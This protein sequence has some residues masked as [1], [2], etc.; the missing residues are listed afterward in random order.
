[1]SSLQTSSRAEELFQEH[2]TALLRQI[3]RFFAGLMLLQWLGGIALALWLSPK[4]WAGTQSS[5]HIHVY[6]A[7]VLGGLISFI[8]ISLALTRPGTVLTRHTIG[9]CQALTSALLIHLSGGR[10]ETHFHVFGSLAFLA[11][12]RDWRVLVTSSAVVA[13]DH[14]LRGAFWPAS[15]YG[16]LSAGNWR[17]LEHAGWVVFEDCFLIYSCQRS[18]REMR[19]IAERQSALETTNASIELQVVERTAELAEARDKALEAARAK[20]EFLA[21]MS[22][23]IRTPMNG[24][25]GM[26]G[27]ILETNLDAEQKDYANTVRTCSESLLSVIND[28]L[29]FS[30]IEAGKL[31]LDVS[32][33][34]LQTM[35][36]ETVDILVTRAEEKGLELIDFVH[37]D[38]PRLLRGDPGRLRQVLLNL[39]NNAV[40]FTERGEVVIRVMPES[41]RG[42]QAIL[43]FEVDDTGI[44]IPADRMDRLFQSFSQVDAS[45]TRRYGGTGLG[46]VICKRLV[47]AMGGQ[48]GVESEAGRGSKFWFTM[49]V[50]IQEESDVEERLLL[51]TQLFGQR[52]LVVDDNATN[53]QVACAHLHAWGLRCEGTGSPQRA[54]QMMHEAAKGTP[55]LVALLD[56]QMPDMDGLQLGAAIKSD[57]VL[58]STRLLLLT[59]VG[60]RGIASLA[61]EIGFAVCLTKP[62]KPGILRTALLSTLQNKDTSW[63]VPPAA[64]PA[65]ERPKKGLP[66]P[67]R[68]LLAE[69]NPINQRVAMRTLQSFGFQPD[70]VG[71][72]AEALSALERTAYDLVLMDCQMPDMDGYEATRKT[73]ERE[74]SARHTPII[75]MTANAMDGDREFCLAAGMDDYVSKPVRP[76]DLAAVID[77]WLAP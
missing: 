19:E 66:R 68:I 24:I 8:P 9:V 14:F 15:V 42:Q 5:I 28:V 76:Q 71:T 16:T 70:V 12:Y 74:G 44:G 33:F 36:D 23:E 41:L 37:P 60:Q 27:L 58:A 10:I 67:E 43:R 3:D 59:S 63:S 46:L 49:A 55:F 64:L 47:E 1:M 69:D 73:R 21:N 48:I 62:V 77:R 54:L 53:R 72:G 18:I 35:L 65:G 20:S 2:H 45:T 52:A 17:W 13:A 56:Y 51:S 34:D 25:I 30:K 22:H 11:F 32:N 29:D 38:V 57:P 50:E 4:A 31:D 75:A 40:K 39:A 6:E 61:Q 26:T 7:I